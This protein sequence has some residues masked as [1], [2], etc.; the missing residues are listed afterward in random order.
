MPAPRLSPLIAAAAAEPAAAA[1][2]F[3]AGFSPLSRCAAAA[4]T[5]DEYFRC[6]RHAATLPLRWL[7]PMLPPFFADFR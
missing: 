2:D 4:D 7:L 5:T 1:F 3:F 6:R